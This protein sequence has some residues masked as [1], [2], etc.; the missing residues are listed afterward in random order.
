MQKLWIC[1]L[2]LVCM[3]S[4]LAAQSMEQLKASHDRY[5]AGKQAS[6]ADTTHS[7]VHFSFCCPKCGC[8]AYTPGP[9]NSK[10]CIQCGNQYTREVAAE[11][12]ANQPPLVSAYIGGDSFSL[13]AEAQDQKFYQDGI[14]NSRK[15][16][17]ELKVTTQM[18]D[19]ATTLEYVVSCVRMETILTMKFYSFVKSQNL[20]DQQKSELSAQMLW[21]A[22]MLYPTLQSQDIKQ[23]ASQAGIALWS[24]AKT[25]KHRQSPPPSEVLRLN[26]FRFTPGYTQQVYNLPQAV[27]DVRW[28]VHQ[29]WNIASYTLKREI[30]NGGFT[31]RIWLDEVRP[32]DMTNW[33]MLGILRYS[34]PALSANSDKA[35]Q[36]FGNCGYFPSH[37]CILQDG[38]GG[39]HYYGNC[40]H[41]GGPCPAFCK[42]GQHTCTF[43]KGHFGPHQFA[44]ACKTAETE[45][46]S[47]E[48]SRGWTTVGQWTVTSPPVSPYPPIFYF[49][50]SGPFSSYQYVV[51]A[52]H[53]VNA[54][55][56]LTR[57]G[58]TL[59]LQV[60][61]YPVQPAPWDI[62][63]LVQV[64]SAG[65]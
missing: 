37:R 44:C 38:H 32:T 21:Q 17:I 42:K 10:I 34:L 28:E 51:V 65:K 9:D 12:A 6:L 19:G 27:A 5:Q 3:C 1:C 62:S 56:R 53:N 64:Q 16:C 13:Y 47:D 29:I 49:T 60:T 52:S 23:I 26:T 4:T 25:Y 54:S 48:E 11:S 31:V 55:I 18:D 61:G 59:V 22:N 33:G 14:L 41:N 46:K 50:P 7:W 36:C 57:Q 43:P 8:P 24:F 40:T 63:G 2:I 20:P 30:S 39:E 35:P 58:D 45:Q 15:D